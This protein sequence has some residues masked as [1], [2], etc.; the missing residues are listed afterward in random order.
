MID[1]LLNRHGEVIPGSENYKP[2]QTHIDMF[3]SLAAQPDDTRGME[4]S[5]LILSTPRCGSTLFC[6]ALNNS[7][8]LG[9][10][11]EWLN[12][13]YFATWTLILDRGHFDLQEYINWIARKTMRNTG[14][15]V[16]HWHVG[17][18]VA[19]NKDFGLGM[20]SLNF[21]RVVYLSRRDKIA[22]AVS[23]AKATSTNQ[24]R[25]YE[26]AAEVANLSFP[27]IAKALKNVADF[28][29]F[30]RTHLHQFVDFE[31]DYEDFRRIGS[32]S[33]FR[34]GHLREEPHECYEIILKEFGGLPQRTYTTGD[35]K[36]Q[37]DDTNRRA[38]SRFLKYITGESHYENG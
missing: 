20:Q 12:Y 18:V 3:K 22:Q 4:Q 14:V 37:G 38:A 34:S 31:W 32:E 36:K 11:D 33:D 15:L 5:L 13:E 23:L 21:K 35:L 6:E 17:Q 10:A 8:Q 19:M 2:K 24:F 29:T 30:A 9:V 28:D 27:A 7:H 26:E 1:K 16:L 25:S